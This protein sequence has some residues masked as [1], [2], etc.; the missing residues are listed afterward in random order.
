MRLGCTSPTS[1]SSELY[2]L[3]VADQSVFPCVRTELG[4]D[5][6]KRASDTKIG[7]DYED[8]EATRCSRK[9]VPAGNLSR[10]EICP[11]RDGF[12]RKLVSELGNPSRPACSRKSVSGGTDFLGN[13][14][15]AGQI[16]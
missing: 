3:L 12:P 4:G 16:S 13:R 10:Q 15:R 5:A 8:L 7:L 14:Y 9:S 1:W 6:G 11:G 2:M